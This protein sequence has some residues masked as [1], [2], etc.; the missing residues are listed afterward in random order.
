M[1]FRALLSNFA[2]AIA[3]KRSECGRELRRKR[4]Q[5]RS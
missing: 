2:L 3:A 1:L 4:H 5:Q